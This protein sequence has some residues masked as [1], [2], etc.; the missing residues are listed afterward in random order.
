MKHLTLAALSIATLAAL[1]GSARADVCTRYHGTVTGNDPSVVVTATLCQNG[2][3]VRGEL[4]WLSRNS[5][6]SIHELSGSWSA[7]QLVLHD[8]Q[9]RG[10]P[11]PGWRFC[12]IDRYALSGAGDRLAGT[13]RSSACRDD[14]TISLVRDR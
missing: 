11:R 4:V 6:R 1:G 7:G 8:V 14:A 12:L 3:T 5:G 13:Y 2:P 10:T 9:L